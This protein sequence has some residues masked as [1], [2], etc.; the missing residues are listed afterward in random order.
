MARTTEKITGDTIKDL[1]RPDKGYR[2]IWDGGDG[3]VK[4]FGVRITAAG[5]VSFIFNYRTKGGLL[6]RLTIGS[7]PSWSIEAARKEARALATDVDRGG[8][9]LATW[10]A[11]REAPVFQ[12]L[13]DFYIER[14]LPKK[15]PASAKNDRQT[16]EKLL[17]PK[18][19]KRKVADITSDEI[20]K[21]H[22]RITKERGPYRANRA[23]AL[24]SKMFALAIKPKKWRDD[25]PAK[26][27]ERNHEEKRERYLSD[28]ELARLTKTLD[29]WP[30]QTIANVVRLL[31]YTGARRGE[32]LG[33]TWK[34]FD[35]EKKTWTKPSASTKQKTEH[36]VP[37]SDEALSLLSKMR[38]EEK[39]ISPYLFPSSSESGHLVEIKKGWAA[40]CKAA[41]LEDLRLHDLR[42]SFASIL[43]AGGASLPMIGALLG[44]T[45]VSTTQRYAHLDVDPLRELVGKVGA[46]VSGAEEVA[47][48]KQ[49]KASAKVTKLRS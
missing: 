31:L 37:L 42:H 39:S 12:D 43:V 3:G 34:Q 49:A 32:V 2:I 24:L 28:D 15:R 33:A 40:I 14:H 8:D 16:I 20:D 30:D 45:Q 9:P 18:L 23:L 19:G 47:A 5:A 21:L 29:A 44:H 6:R 4:G 11:K 26:G 1:E 7:P 35:L 13:A 17:L 38:A 27:I 22:Q 48:E 10:N 41:E 36:R 46:V 25:N